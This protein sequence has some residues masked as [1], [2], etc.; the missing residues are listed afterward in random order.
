[1]NTKNRKLPKCLAMALIALELV[2][3]RKR[4]DKGADG[5]ENAEVREND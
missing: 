2:I 4:L 1:M 3:F 5:T